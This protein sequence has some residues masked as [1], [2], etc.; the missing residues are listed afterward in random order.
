MKF[1]MS[2]FT[3]TEIKERFAQWVRSWVL[4]NNLTQAVESGDY[5]TVFRVA[6]ATHHP[7][8]VTAILKYLFNKGSLMKIN[9]T[10]GE[11]AVASDREA[12]LSDDVIFTAATATT[13]YSLQRQTKTNLERRMAGFQIDTNGI[14]GQTYPEVRFHASSTQT[15]DGN[16]MHISAK[17]LATKDEVRV[18]EVEAS[19]GD[20]ISQVHPAP[21][22]LPPEDAALYLRKIATNCIKGV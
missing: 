11:Q 4:E 8:V 13:Q 14:T 16:S 6:S 7:T 19:C 15:V 17:C 12:S 3:S 10:L 2:Y 1:G 9:V 20:R 22:L 21:I 18:L 5:E